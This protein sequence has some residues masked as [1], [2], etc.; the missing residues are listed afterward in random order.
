MVIVLAIPSSFSTTIF[1]LEEHN[2]DT[3]NMN[4]DV[5]VMSFL[6]DDSEPMKIHCRSRQ[7]D[8]G[9]H[10]LNP[11]EEYKWV[12]QEKALYTSVF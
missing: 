7:T 3:N 2:I 1:A 5:H 12:A 9:G 11:G 8:L 10:T 4:T 6:P